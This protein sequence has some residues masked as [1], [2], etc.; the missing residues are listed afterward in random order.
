MEF[1]Q[2]YLAD[3]NDSKIV[4][5]AL[6]V[7]R[8]YR[9]SIK[10]DVDGL[11]S[12]FLNEKTPPEVLSAAIELARVQKY[13]VPVEL[14][15]HALS[16]PSSALAALR[17]IED[18]GYEDELIKQSLE[19]SSVFPH[20]KSSDYDVASFAIKVLADRDWKHGVNFKASD[21]PDLAELLNLG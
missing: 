7:V 17:Y 5:A 1:L 4:S 16:D 6:Q 9:G 19:V 3:G 13:K 8:A 14:L 10:I 18:Y 20:L 11:C 2:S 15:N 21:I 12:R